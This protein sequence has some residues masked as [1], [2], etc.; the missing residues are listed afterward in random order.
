[1]RKTIFAGAVLLLGACASQTSSVTGQLTLDGDPLTITRCDAGPARG[2][3]GVDLETASGVRV[4]LVHLPTGVAHAILF[5]ESAAPPTELGACGEISVHHN[6]HLMLTSGSAN[7]S[8]TGQGRT[9][10]GRVSYSDCGDP[11]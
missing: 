11:R 1:M 6:M 2:F 4:R 5:D 9:L 3:Y 7:V 10:A 8:C